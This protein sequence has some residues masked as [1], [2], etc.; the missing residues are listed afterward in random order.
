MTA[1]SPTTAVA[2][3]FFGNSAI[4]FEP[5]ERAVL[6][7]SGGGDSTALLF[8]VHDYWVHTL[9]RDP[10]LLR[11]VTVNHGVR[12][13]AFEEA[14]AVATWCAR[15]GIGH[16]EINWDG[17]EVKS[18]FQAAAREAR[19]EKLSAY[20]RSFGNAVV[21]TGHTLDDQLETLLMRRQRRHDGAG[22]AG[23][24]PAT[25]C[26][27]RTWFVRPL[28]HVRRDAL[29]THLRSRGLT[30]FDDPSNSD[31]AYERVRVRQ[32]PP[33]ECDSLLVDAYKAAS[34]RLSNAERGAAWIRAHA[35]LAQ[36]EKFGVTVRLPILAFGQPKAFVG[37]AHLL[38][39]VGA[40]T[41]VPNFEKV[42]RAIA[43]CMKHNGASFTLS[44][45][46]LARRGEEIC[47]IKELRNRHTGPFG[48]DQL[49]PVW[50]TQI[51]AAIDDLRAIDRV[52]FPLFCRFG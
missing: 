32:N 21:M 8:L 46:L 31:S 16:H 4:D 19:Y 52:P 17:R 51:L 48:F 43:A 9:K 1:A 13:E 30:W 18:G 39:L 24:A 29:R 50:E 35:R 5:I 36:D 34:L 7:V 23:I 44:G 12:D 28:L 20:A 10:S 2:E 40:Q 27:R 42:E 47:I 11:A 37:T 26:T 22:M 3:G 25:L 6:A 33:F 14:Q 49:M 38:M 15:L 45:C 41:S